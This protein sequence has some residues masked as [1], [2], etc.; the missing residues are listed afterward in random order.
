[1][2]AAS[3]EDEDTVYTM[4]YAL[5][6]IA[7]LIGFLL[8]LIRRED[9]SP[10]L[11]LVFMF[12]IIANAGY[13]WLSQSQNIRE[14]ILAVKFTY[15]GALWI[16]FF[17]YRIVA[18][19]CAVPKSRWFFAMLVVWGTAMMCFVFTIGITTWYYKSMHLEE[20]RGS[21]VLIRDYGPLHFLHILYLLFYTV[22]T[23]DA[24]RWGASHREKL[25]FRFSKILL[26]IIITNI[27]LYF[28]RL[29]THSLFDFTSVA[30]VVSCYILLYIGRN[31]LLYDADSLLSMDTENSTYGIILFDP[32][33]RFMGASKGIRPVV[34][35]LGEL[36]IERA[37]P[38]G[39]SPECRQLVKWTGGFRNGSLDEICILDVGSKSYRCSIDTYFYKKHTARNFLGYIIYLQDET[40]M[41]NH[42]RTVRS[43]NESLLAKERE[44]EQLN[45]SL[46]RSMEEA[47]QANVAK[48]QFLAKMSHELRTP[49][50]AVLGM[51]EMILRENEDAS[52]AEYA[53]NIK[54]AGNAL[55]SQINDILDF[56]KIESG[57]LEIILSD[58]RLSDI[59]SDVVLLLCDKATSKG[60]KFV[61]DVDKDI[62]DGLHGDEVRLRQIL[63]N[64]LNNAVKYTEKG[65][66]LLSA[67]AEK[68]ASSADEVLLTFHVRDTG[69]G[70][71]EE[72]L[73]KVFSPFHRIEE[74][75]IRT[76]EGSGLGM[77]ITKQLLE[78]M[79]S[80]LEVESVYG[81]GS[82]F[83]FSVRQHIWSHEAVGKFDARMRQHKVAAKPSAELFHA[84]DARIL[85][86][87]DTPMNL[88]VVKDLLKRTMVQIDTAADGEQSLEMLRKNA[89]D[90]VFM[91]HLMPGMDGVATLHEIQKAAGDMSVDFPNRKTP[92]IILTANAIAGVREKF[93][94]E[95]FVD[96]LSKPVNPRLLEGMLLKYLPERLV[97]RVELEPGMLIE[98]ERPRDDSAVNRLKQGLAKIDGI[99]VSVG[100]ENCGSEDTFFKVLQEFASTGANR[101]AQIEHDLGEH[102]IRNYTVR[103]HALKSAARLI[104]AQDLS[105]Q[106]AYLESCGNAM[107]IGEITTYTPN[108]LQHLVELLEQIQELFPEEAPEERKP[109][110]AERLDEAYTAIRELAS[111]GDFNS[112]DLIMAELKGSRIPDERLADYNRL[113]EAVDAVDADAVLAVLNAGMAAEA[114]GGAS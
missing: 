65:S 44:L 20:V 8:L 85:V 24:I 69:I 12:V 36:E 98:D 39:A 95:G 27:S 86:V 101:L 102:D 16:P 105:R 56:S 25:A 111:V 114:A 9:V 93:L 58:Y 78:M 107:D 47:Q 68:I 94:A 40:M 3:V 91:D 62:P 104:G 113:K 73:P 4:F 61:V 52:I 10:E 46:K 99:D 82:D 96:Y 88:T 5:A 59:L 42:V 72:D 33:L 66:V 108:L 21:T 37:V 11:I 38:A 18:R 109:I 60:L 84:P 97:Q 54:N 22:I 53:E 31:M 76:I 83:Y 51:N 80:R 29:L 41:Q 1:M 89:Y 110:S 43:Y 75:R 35:G 57:R 63:V 30:Y 7:E 19:I 92:V 49:I 112:I 55:L 13:L 106:A 77:S 6:L 48:S 87:D 26:A 71:R 50:N 90:I 23:A 100:I 103:V 2:F 15:L 34:P 81:K 74:K 45:L 70:I 79:G 14:A 17:M 67:R 64:I 32:Q 28:M